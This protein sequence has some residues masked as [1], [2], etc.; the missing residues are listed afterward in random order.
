MKKILSEEKRESVWFAILVNLI[1]LGSLLLV[2]RPSFET[3]DD[4][5]IALFINGA[6]GSY[7]A[8]LIYANYVLGM[9]LAG[10]YRICGRFPWLALFQYASLFLSFT[11]VFYVT[12]RRLK[13]SS[14]VWL[15]LFVIWIFA[16]DGYIRLQYTKTAGIVSAAGILL[17]LYAAETAK[18]TRLALA[19]GYLLSMIGFMLRSQQFLAELAL[20]SGIGLFLLLERPERHAGQTVRRLI[21]CAVSFGLLLVLIVGL[22]LT[23]RY[24]YRSPQWQEYL[25]YNELR[26][27]LLDYGFPDYSENKESYQ[28]L[29][30]NRTAYR[31]YRGWN[32]ADTEK[33]TPE[34]M[35]ELIALKQ[36]RT[37]NA[38][39]LRDFLKEVP[40]K[41][42]QRTSFCCLL[43]I[44]LYVFFWGRHTKCTAATV[45]Y[46]LLLLAAL[47]LYLYYDGRYLYNRVDVGLWFAAI[48]VLL[49]TYSQGKHYFN[50]QAGLA[51]LAATVLFTSVLWKDTW[52]SNTASAL[53]KMQEERATLESI[54]SDKEHLYVVKSGAISF[55]KGYGAFDHVPYGIS[56]NILLLG[57]WPALTPGYRA[58]ME[59]YG[60]TN[61]Y[62]DLPGSEKLYLV[63]RDIDTTM[64]YIHK[65]YDDTAQAVLV[66]EY[67]N[68]N[69]YQITSGK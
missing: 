15:S 45:L 4:M 57:G 58:L 22:S 47:Y 35:R 5:A 50:S 40:Y 63:D 67:P 26:T 48:L 51:F 23:D 28:K 24:A 1:V 42:I 11:A 62:R 19:L 17:L 18:R 39:L 34:I 9:I 38:Q 31:L 68:C 61:P 27:E 41:L 44:L 64:D 30:I 8:H 66:S 13:N 14:S 33:F 32:H 12:V 2:F 46:E 21:R 60:V 54:G 36:P 16:Y 10:L 25:E 69:V 6:K 56:Q 29:G 7:D 43:L 53:E 52:R 59:T 20:M 49:W 65:Y 55:A 37:F 3:N